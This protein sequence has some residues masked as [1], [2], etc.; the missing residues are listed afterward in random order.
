MSARLHGALARF[1]SASELLDAARQARDQGYRRMDA[2]SPFPV[3]GLAEVLQAEDARVPWLVFLCG[4]AGAVV[5][6]ALQ[7]FVSVVDYPHNVG[8][9][10]FHSWPSFIPVTFE[11]TVLLAAFGAVFGMFAL[12][13]LPRPHHP[14]FGA[15]GFDRASTD[16]FFLC[17]EADDPRYDQVTT[18]RF[19]EDLGALEVAE[20]Q[21]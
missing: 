8:G 13:G 7:Y 3:H 21:Q 2:Y 4:A 20:V 12:N 19:L 6:Y 15:R 18:A 16:A 5:G 11:T 1:G 10:P 14:V 9:R 17:I